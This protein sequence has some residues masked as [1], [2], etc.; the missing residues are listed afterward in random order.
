MLHLLEEQIKHKGTIVCIK[1]LQAFSLLLQS[2]AFCVFNLSFSSFLSLFSIMKP[3]E[4]QSE[5][6][7]V[8]LLC[9][10]VPASVFVFFISFCKYIFDS[11]VC[12]C[13]YFNIAPWK[14]P[15]FTC[16]FSDIHAF[17]IWTKTQQ[18]SPFS[19][20]I[21]II[22]F[23]SFSFFFVSSTH[24][25]THLRACTRAHISSSFHHECAAEFPALSKMIKLDIF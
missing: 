24:I 8:G 2:P 4:S 9:P 15:F 5:Y 11:F 13:M 22:S 6:V 10:D 12:A 21:I 3:A 25:Y 14:P 19:F 23:P 1:A 17:V 18:F 20:P 7:Q 16:D